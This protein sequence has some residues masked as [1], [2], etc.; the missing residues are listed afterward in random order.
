MVPHCQVGVESV[1]L[2]NHAHAAVFRRQHGHIVFTEE[3]PAAAGAEKTADKIERC[4]LSA[5]GGAEQTHKLTIGDF[6]IK[7]IYGY[8]FPRLVF[9]SAGEYF[10]QMFKFKLHFP[11]HLSATERNER[12]GVIDKLIISRC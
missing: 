12:I 8:Y 9:V 10:R 6:K 4:A 3:N 2:K 11:K 5:A 1:I 7:V